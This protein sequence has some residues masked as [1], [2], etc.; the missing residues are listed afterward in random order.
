MRVGSLLASVIGWLLLLLLLRLG[1]L[2]PWMERV[3]LMATLHPL[4][5]WPLV[6][7]KQLAAKQRNI[8]NGSLVTNWFENWFIW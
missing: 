1:A 5:H 2:L 3:V 8:H 6:T 4:R 7:I